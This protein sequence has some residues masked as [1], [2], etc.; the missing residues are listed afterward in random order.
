MALQYD[1]FISYANSDNVPLSE[2]QKGWVS[3]FQKF[4]DTM[5]DQLLGLDVKFA[6]SFDHPE[7][8]ERA[9]IF[10]S[11]LS[12][13]SINASNCTKELNS[14]LKSTQDHGVK[15]E[16]VSRLF[17]IIKTP[18]SF[19]QQPE[20]LR[21]ILSYDFYQVDPETAKAY[22][23]TDFFNSAAEKSY[24]VKLVD[25]AYDVFK[26]LSEMRTSNSYVNPFVQKDS[27]YLAETTHD[28]ISERDVIKRELQRHGYRVLPDHNLPHEPGA[29][30]ASIKKYI[31]QCKLS[32]HMIGSSYGDYLPGTELSMIDMEN[33]IA[34][35]YYNK[36]LTDNRN[37]RDSKEFSRLVWLP[38]NLK[39]NSEIQK[40]FIEGLRRESLGAEV[41]QIPLEDL[42]A[43]MR[44][45][46]ISRQGEYRSGGDEENKEA[47]SKAKIYIICDQDDLKASEPLAAYFSKQGFDVL[48]NTFEGDLIGLRQSHQ[49]S[50]RNCDASIIYNGKS[51]AEWVK[52]K[53]QDLMKAPGLGRSKPLLAKA[54]FTES[55]E[56]SGRA[57]FKN[58]DAIFI[59]AKGGFS[60]EQLEPFLTKIQKGR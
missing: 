10:I 46:L 5:L 3:N 45:K 50:L 41:L 21:E 48:R 6:T 22:E 23:F 51:T 18:V 7:E 4:L 24:W 32:I 25:L 1:V 49:E 39:I 36:V 57:E 52:A 56:H 16:I 31:Q 14:F 19:D 40:A 55:L 8:A 26:V 44:A 38:V 58:D 11:I 60:P 9:R 43:I 42:K 27:I 53:L 54:I 37:L 33:R 28:L 13:H 17:K 35:E 59:S 47:G 30:E 20:V 12:S 2:D 34:S 29:L 15:K